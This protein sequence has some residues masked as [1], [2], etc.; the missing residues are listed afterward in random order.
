MESVMLSTENIINAI[1]RPLLHYY[2]K[3]NNHWNKM[4]SNWH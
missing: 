1:I 3:V 4:S 2:T